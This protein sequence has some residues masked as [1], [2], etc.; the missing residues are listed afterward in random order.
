MHTLFRWVLWK[1]CSQTC[2]MPSYGWNCQLTCNCSNDQCHRMYGCQRLQSECSNGRISHYSEVSCPY[3]NYGKECQLQCRCNKELCDPA[4]G[5]KKQGNR[6]LT[7]S[8]R[9]HSEITYSLKATYQIEE[10]KNVTTVLNTK[11]FIR[12]VSGNEL[13]IRRRN[14][15]LSQDIKDHVII[16]LA[17]LVLILL[18]LY[19]SLNVKQRTKIPQHSI[20]NE[21]IRLENI[22]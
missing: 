9:R 19:I 3:P 7:P 21:Q 22:D 20:T 15:D 12:N 10:L 11:R 5:C 17:I 2:P 18:A 1:N 14:T 8:S 6:T 13:E 16:S 4:T